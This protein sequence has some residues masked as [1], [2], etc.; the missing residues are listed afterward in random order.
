MMFVVQCIFVVVIIYIRRLYV[1][2]YVYE[3][4]WM[5]LT[6]MYDTVNGSA[7]MEKNI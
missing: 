7:I 1:C 5:R 6:A 2:I 3:Y 4:V